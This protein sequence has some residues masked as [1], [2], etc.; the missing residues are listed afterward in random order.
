M[1]HALS[2]QLATIK[3]KSWNESRPFIPAYINK[4]K[5]GNESRPFIPAYIN[6]TRKLE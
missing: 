5:S 2:F 6:K 4:T 1:N 3:L